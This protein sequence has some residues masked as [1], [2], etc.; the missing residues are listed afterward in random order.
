MSNKTE[1]ITDSTYWL[2]ICNWL[3]C[4]FVVTNRQVFW[5]DWGKT[6]ILPYV[7]IEE[8]RYTERMNCVA[9]GETEDGADGN[10][11]MIMWVNKGRGYKVYRAVD[12]FSWVSETRWRNDSDHVGSRRLYRNIGI[13]LNYKLHNKS[14]DRIPQVDMFTVMTIKLYTCSEKCFPE[15]KFEAP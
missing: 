11:R 2:V 15:S 10:V 4:G 3:Q 9:K 7:R 8:F 5:R 1:I 12:V 14:E 13:K 6:Q